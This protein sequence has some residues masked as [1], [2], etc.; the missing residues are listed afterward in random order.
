M[1]K[2]ILCRVA[3][4]IFMIVVLD[5]DKELVPVMKAGSVTAR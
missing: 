3:D 2:E 1:E 5:D 4:R